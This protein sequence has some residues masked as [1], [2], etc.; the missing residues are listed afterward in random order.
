MLI[1][2]DGVEVAYCS[3]WDDCSNN[4]EVSPPTAWSYSFT[5][6]ELALL[7]D[8]A[9]D[10]SVSKEYLGY[11]NLGSLTLT[12]VNDVPEPASAALLLAGLA[13]LGWSRRARRPKA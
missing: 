3:L 7:Q 2:G 10:L 8:G 11:V 12:L 6:A 5:G 9:L 13:G 4:S 1:Y